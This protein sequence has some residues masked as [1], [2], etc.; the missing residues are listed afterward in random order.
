MKKLKSD[1][2]VFLIIREWLADAEMSV[3]S[4]GT[5]YYY[6]YVH[7]HGIGHALWVGNSHAV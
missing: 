5:W 1:T 2:F 7:W 3:F 6:M 4:G